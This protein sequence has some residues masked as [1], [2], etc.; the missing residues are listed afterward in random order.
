MKRNLLA[1]AVSAAMTASLLGGCGGSNQKAA[2]STVKQEETTKAP[3][4]DEKTEEAEP[5]EAGQLDLSGQEISI[6]GSY[7]EDMVKRL[8]EMFE[9]RTGCKVSYLRMPTGEAVAKMTAEKDNPSVN[10]YLGGTVDG[11]ENLVQQ[12]LLVPYKS[13][14]EAEIPSEYLD[15]N[16]VWKSQYIETLSIGVNTER[17]EKEFADSGLEMPTT[18]EELINPA[19]K[20]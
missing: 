12:G 10:V 15:P 2:E 16:G 14:T 17:W 9:E 4:S 18:L 8:A 5:A 20:G 1:I 11:H 7:H 6:L 3:E 19:F 13:S